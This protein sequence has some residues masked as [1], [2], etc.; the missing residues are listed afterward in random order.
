MTTRPSVGSQQHEKK[1]RGLHIE[2]QRNG[3][4]EASSETGK[5][6]LRPTPAD[7]WRVC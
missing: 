7:G 2:R 5:A 3:T 6:G 4:L 1:S